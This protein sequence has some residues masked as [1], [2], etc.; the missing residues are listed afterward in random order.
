MVPHFPVHMV[1]QSL[2]KRHSVSV[3][4]YVYVAVQGRRNPCT[5]WPSSQRQE[6]E[7]GLV[8]K[9][10]LYVPQKRPEMVLVHDRRELHENIK[11]D[12][13]HQ[14]MSSNRLQNLTQPAE[15]STIDQ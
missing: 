13:K 15:A 11:H 10:M 5:G 2:Y 4:I 14:L 9:I 6:R 1:F 3:K 12:F 8:F 7:D